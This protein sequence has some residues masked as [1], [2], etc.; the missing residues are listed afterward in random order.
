V[1]I[2]GPRARQPINVVLDTGAECCL[3]PAWAAWRVGLRQSPA[4]PTVTMGSS[5]SRTGWSAWFEIVDLVLEDPTGTVPPFR[6]S[7]VVGFTGAGSFAGSHSGVLGVNGG[8]DRFQRVEFD[9]SALGG[10]EVVVRA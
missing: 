3:F 2:I 4:S 1:F 9:W 5:V 10:P 8:L 6:W 7:A